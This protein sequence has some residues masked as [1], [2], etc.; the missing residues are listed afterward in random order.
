[1]FTLMDTKWK[2]SAVYANTNG[3]CAKRMNRTIAK[4]VRSMWSHVKLLKSYW[5]EA[6]MIDVYLINISP[7]NPLDGDVPQ[8]VWTRRDIVSY[9]HLRVFGCLA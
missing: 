7:S 6:M 5:A 2:E 3:Q 4:R 9:K 8:R 1:M